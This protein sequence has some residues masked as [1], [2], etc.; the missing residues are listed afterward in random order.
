MRAVRG[1]GLLLASL[2]GLA[3]V[4][5]GGPVVLD[6]GLDEPEEPEDEVVAIGEEDTGIAP[7]VC[8]NELLPSN[9]S[10]YELDSGAHPDWVELHNPEE[11]DV[12]LDG[13]FLSDDPAEPLKWAL[14]GELNNG[15][16]LVLT[17]GEGGEDFDFG[18]S[19]EGGSVLLSDPWGGGS[20]IDY[21][22]VQ[23]DFAVARSSDCC[24]GAGCLDF[25][26]G[27]TPGAPNGDD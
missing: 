25:V 3:L 9:V 2:C 6:V 7:G 5:C 17:G 13:W 27:G 26:R 4:A 24:S 21:G 23:D 8:V 14:T 11:H 16:Y 22:K 1:P 12:D 10:S 19:A 18:L 15:D 20:R